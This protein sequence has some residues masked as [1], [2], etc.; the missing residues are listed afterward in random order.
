MNQPIDG[1]SLLVQVLNDA[2]RKKSARVSS[3]ICFGGKY[4]DLYP[5]IGTSSI[6]RKIKSKKNRGLIKQFIDE[7]IPNGMGVH[8]RESFDVNNLICMKA[9]TLAQIQ[10]VEKHQ[11]KNFKKSI[12]LNTNAI[13]WCSGSCDGKVS[14]RRCL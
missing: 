3:N 5:V 12:T 4:L 11:R 6:S 2:H 13:T 14:K 9:V 10:K 8:I 1:E 7:N